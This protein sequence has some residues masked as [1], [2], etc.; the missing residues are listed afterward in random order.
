MNVLILGASGYLGKVLYQKCLQSKDVTVCGTTRRSKDMRFLPLDV[1]DGSAVTQ[2]I[3]GYKPNVI[4]W[5]LCDAE[6]EMMLSEMALPN[7]I[8]QLNPDTRLIYIST[9]VSS[10]EN[11]TEEVK[12]EQRRPEAY[13]A[14]YVNGKILGESLVREHPNHVIIRPGQI[15]GFGA[16]GEYDCRMNRI[17]EQKKTG[18]TY[19]RYD[20]AYTSIIHVE[21]LADCIIELFSVD[22]TGIINIASARPVSFFEFYTMLAEMMGINPG[23]VEPEHVKNPQSNFMKV[24]KAQSILRTQLRAE[25]DR[26]N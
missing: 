2:I 24:S 4:V 23:I 16:D 3:D 11:Q 8:R 9:T 22:F 26:I 12:P 7:L 21:N 15:Y 10:Q 20:N 18:Q 13:L 5:C 1:L 25:A 19:K 14:N 17:W 6:N